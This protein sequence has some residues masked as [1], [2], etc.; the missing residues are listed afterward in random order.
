MGGFYARNCFCLIALHKTSF[1][2]TPPHQLL[3][4]RMLKDGAV[5]L[6]LHI[7]KREHGWL[8]L[9]RSIITNTYIAKASGYFGRHVARKKNSMVG[10]FSER[11]RLRHSRKISS[12]EKGQVQAIWCFKFFHSHIFSLHSNFPFSIYIF[13]IRESIFPA[14]YPWP[15]NYI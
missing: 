9:A 13:C 14:H 6:M 15:T 8:F 1:L 7:A 2:V 12:Y 5:N 4:Y 3:G 11:R 10:N